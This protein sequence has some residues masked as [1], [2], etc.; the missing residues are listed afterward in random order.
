M[1]G[2]PPFEVGAV[3]DTAI[4]SAPAVSVGAPGTPGMVAGMASARFDQP[5]SP[6]AFAARTRTWYAVPLV[7]P[8]RLAEVAVSAA[9]SPERSVQLPHE[10]G[11][12]LQSR[13]VD[14][15]QAR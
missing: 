3:H 15:V 1:I 9:V 10:V 13:P 5:L 4:S 14:A 7:R 8:V 6:L 11:A 12:V 2:D